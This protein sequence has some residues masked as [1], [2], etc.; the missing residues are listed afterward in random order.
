MIVFD[1]SQFVVSMSIPLAL[2]LRHA[3]FYVEGVDGRIW[4]L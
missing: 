2:R 4:L 1:P 3:N